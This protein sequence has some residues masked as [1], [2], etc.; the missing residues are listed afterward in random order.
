[1]Q[2]KTNVDDKLKALETQYWSAIK[3]RDSSAAALLSAEPCLVVGAQ[4]V[5]ELD[6][7]TLARTLDEGRFELEDFDLENVH[8]RRLGD[9][10]AIVAYQVKE[11]LVVEGETVRLKAF[12]SSVWV[13]RDGKWLCALHTE[14]LEGDPYGR[15]RAAA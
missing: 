12:D 14:S 4:G 3:D 11:D 8:V 9:D 13:R 15:S 10:V 1:M 2:S 7:K 5:A 6:R